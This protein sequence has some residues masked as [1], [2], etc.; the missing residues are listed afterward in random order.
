MPG[1]NPRQRLLAHCRL[2]SHSARPG[3]PSGRARPP[4]FI[5]YCTWKSTARS[6]GAVSCKLTAWRPPRSGRQPGCSVSRHNAARARARALQRT[7]VA[8]EEHLPLAQVDA[9]AHGVARPKL[10]PIVV[11]V[12]HGREF[13]AVVAMVAVGVGFPAARRGLREWRA[14]VKRRS[15][16]C[17]AGSAAACY[18]ACTGTHIP[19]A[20]CDTPDSYD[21]VE[22]LERKAHQ[23][24]WR[25]SLKVGSLKPM[26]MRPSSPWSRTVICRKWRRNEGQGAS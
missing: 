17:P 21:T 19:C 15:N 8:R 14:A 4:Q 7:A 5:T 18:R 16:A 1:A 2:Q 12:A 9:G 26:A 3:T 23:P 10:G 25:L 24:G 22:D 20:K 6:S 13:L 11:P